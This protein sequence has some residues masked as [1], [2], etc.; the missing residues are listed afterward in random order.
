MSRSLSTLDKMKNVSFLPARETSL[1]ALLKVLRLLLYFVCC[2]SLVVYFLSYSWLFSYRG[3]LSDVRL[4]DVSWFSLLLFVS[5]IV[6]VT[7]YTMC[8]ILGQY[9]KQ[10]RAN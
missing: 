8:C 4:F 3:C 10:R 6:T 5:F 2:L 9:N 7:W 1:E